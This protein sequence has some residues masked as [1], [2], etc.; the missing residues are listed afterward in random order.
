MPCGYTIVP[1]SNAIEFFVDPLLGSDQNLGQS[2]AQAFRTLQRAIEEAARVAEIGIDAD[3]KIRPSNG[4][5]A[6]DLKINFS[7]APKR[8]VTI[9]G[10]RTTM[11]VIASGVATA[12]TGATSLVDAGAAFGAAEEQTGRIIEWTVGGFPFQ[13]EIATHT[14]TSIRPAIPFS[15]APVVGTAYRV[16]EPAVVITGAPGSD[17]FQP[18]ILIDLPWHQS[19]DQ[20]GGAFAGGG[21]FLILSNL[22]VVASKSTHHIIVQ[23]GAVEFCGVVLDGSS[24]GLYLSGSVAAFFGP[25]G[26]DPLFGLT[27]QDL[28]GLSLGCRGT[29]AFSEVRSDEGGW[30]GHVIA[31][32]SGG[33][34]TEHTRLNIDGGSIV[35][36]IALRGDRKT[37]VDITSDASLPVLFKNVPAGGRALHMTKGS[38]SRVASPGL[39]ELRSFGAGSVAFDATDSGSM[40][41]LSTNPTTGG[42]A[43]GIGT[44][45]RVQFGALAQVAAAVSFTTV[46]AELAA[47]GTAATFAALTPTTPITD[48]TT[49]PQSNARIFEG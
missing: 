46:T 44:G 21:P 26:P 27:T 19:P 2:F 18:T 20:L 45:V 7:R 43:D 34:F 36:G 38:W 5:Y 29:S 8:R 12:G 35:S 17:P 15:P 28:F 24:N 9:D 13:A 23:G 37:V 16:L 31:R 41:I 4:T 14:G 11:T 47:G 10:D 40:I 49:S 32:C 1:A 22:R 3:V 30:N 25:V 48:L 33:I 6:E 39:V 42:A